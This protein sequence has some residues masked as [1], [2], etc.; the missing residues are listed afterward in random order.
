MKANCHRRIS[1]LNKQL[2]WLENKFMFMNKAYLTITGELYHSFVFRAINPVSQQANNI[3]S[4]LIHGGDVDRR[5][6]H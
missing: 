3:E 1:I 6:I 4:T 5:L 2:D